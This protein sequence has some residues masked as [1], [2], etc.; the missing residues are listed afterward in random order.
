MSCW[1]SQSDVLPPTGAEGLAGAMA[2][3][4]RLGRGALGSSSAC[5][6]S[7]IN[8]WFKERHSFLQAVLCAVPRHLTPMLFPHSIYKCQFQQG[9]QLHVGDPG[10]HPSSHITTSFVILLPHLRQNSDPTPKV[11]ARK[12]R[13]HAFEC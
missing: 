7:Q 5:S 11:A 10:P 3:S 12:S 1:Q 6:L 8:T 2:S 4:W 9:H 13:E